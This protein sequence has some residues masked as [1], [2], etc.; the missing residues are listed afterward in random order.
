LA[1]LSAPSPLGEEH[2]VEGFRCTSP[3]LT[4]WLLERAHKNQREGASRCFVVCDARRNVVGYYAL[5]AGQISHAEAP[6]PVRRNMPDPIPVAILA[7]LAVH[8]AWTGQGI[9]RGLLKDAELRILQAAQQMGIRVLLCHAI[10]T[11]AK[12][13]YRHFDFIESPVEPMTM[14]LSIPAL[15]ARLYGRRA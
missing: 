4:K 5:A 15:Q 3:A 12:A 14:M 9:G 10:D 13:F 6:G 11:S 2:V 1:A 7:R 8:E